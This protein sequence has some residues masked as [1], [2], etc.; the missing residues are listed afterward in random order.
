MPLP[1][2]RLNPFY[3][4]PAETI[5]HWCAV[6]IATAQLYKA[7]KRKPSVQA[8]RL[9]A[10]YQ[11]NR[12]LT[13]EWEGW[14]VIGNSLYD[15]AGNAFKASR[16]EGYQMILQWVSA[17][18]AIYP[19]TKAQYYEV[20]RRSELSGPRT[21]IPALRVIQEG[22]SEVNAR[23]RRRRPA[24]RQPSALLRLPLIREHAVPIE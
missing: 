11:E 24:L 16:L 17:V 14:R 7:G 15:P 1:I 13:N 4:Y 12:V 23:G 19:D 5:A 20:L 18:A 21:P 22:G 9:F 6:S 8:L 10:L 2:S 3:G